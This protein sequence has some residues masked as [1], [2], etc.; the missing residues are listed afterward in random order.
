MLTLDERLALVIE[1]IEELGFDGVGGFMAAFLNTNNAG[2]KRRAQ[3]FT[4]HIDDALIGPLFHHAR[5]SKSKLSAAAKE[6]FMERTTNVL[7]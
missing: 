1:K 3:H 6:V 4:Q 5:Y 7:M 2:L